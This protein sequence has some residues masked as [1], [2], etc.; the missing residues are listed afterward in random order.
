MGD[1]PVD[2]PRRWDGGSALGLWFRCITSSNA[3][4]RLSHYT[5]LCHDTVQF[6]RWQPCKIGYLPGSPTARLRRGDH[7]GDQVDPE[8]HQVV[9]SHAQDVEL[10][11]YAHTATRSGPLICADHDYR[12]S[13]SLMRVR[14]SAALSAERPIGVRHAGA[15]AFKADVFE[16]CLLRVGRVG[17]RYRRTD[18]RSG[19]RADR[20]AGSGFH[21]VPFHGGSDPPSNCS[22]TLAY[23]KPGHRSFDTA[24][25]SSRSLP[26]TLLRPHSADADDVDL[27]PRLAHH[28]VHEHM[29]VGT[30][31]DVTRRAL[32]AGIPAP[33]ARSRPAR[34]R[35][36]RPRVTSAASASR[37]RRL[38]SPSRAKQVYR[39]V[40]T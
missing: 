40:G 1:R 21:S 3:E 28:E 24:L 23:A 22:I 27:R 4:N 34:S 29:C 12:I 10:E 15:Y 14:S 13:F 19:G 5:S 25:D 2:Q 32:P 9:F 20:R 7:S 17:C 35:R 31:V 37:G 33:T 39:E 6:C 30:V 26:N 8:V 11:G 38:R 36:A 16:L 18:A